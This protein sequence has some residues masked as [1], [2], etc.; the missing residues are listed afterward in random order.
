[1]TEA[2]G[3]LFVIG[4][5]AVLY[6]SAAVLVPV[7]HQ[8]VVEIIE[9]GR[10]QVTIANEATRTLSLSEAVTA[11]PLLS[12]VV[13]TLDCMKEID[14]LSLSLDTSAFFFRGQKLGLGSSAALTAA[15]VKA[16]RP[17][18]SRSNQLIL[19][20]SAHKLFQAGRGSG[21]DVAT[22]AMGSSICFKMDH[23]VATFSFPK[24]LH[25]LAIW[26]GESASTTSY[27]KK[28]E[29]WRAINPD[30]F[31]YHIERLSKCTSDFLEAE[32]TVSQ[33]SNIQLYDRYLH[34]LSED[35][36]V[37]CYNNSHI[38]LQKEVES[39]RGI[40]KPSGAG[41]GD[42]GIAFSRDEDIL[43]SLAEKIVQEGRLAFRIR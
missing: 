28:V 14:S 15:L 31:E 7:P 22:A 42:F 33:M 6:G 17:G 5:Y 40:Y 37:K 1:M 29:A 10:N 41:G 20:M 13:Q 16:L 38:T 4:E 23:P 9:D 19:A 27:L 34:D 12:A 2:T 35:S 26:T 11:E 3:K 43:S 25:M 21:A 39:A 30:R 36:K 18:L 32:N 8:A 24:D